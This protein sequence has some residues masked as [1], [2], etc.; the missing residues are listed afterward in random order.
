LENDEEGC[1][2]PI[3]HYVLDVVVPCCKDKG[4]VDV[5]TASGRNKRKSKVGKIEDN[6]VILKVKVYGPVY[7]VTDA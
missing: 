6:A 1:T 3:L 2:H 5:V 7:F 4:S